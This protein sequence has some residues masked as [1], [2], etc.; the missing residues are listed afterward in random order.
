MAAKR[1]K[2]RK[3]DERQI[4]LRILSG[5]NT[6]DAPVTDMNPGRHAEH[7]QFRRECISAYA[8]VA[9][10]RPRA[11]RPPQPHR[12]IPFDRAQGMLRPGSGNPSE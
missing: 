7:R 10:S 11:N 5:G 4:L 1:R 12:E 6:R 3:R 9:A 2:K 8:L